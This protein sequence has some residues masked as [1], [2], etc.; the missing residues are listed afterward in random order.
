MRMRKSPVIKLY[1]L[2]CR[3]FMCI[4]KMIDKVGGINRCL[5]RWLSS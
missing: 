3:A 4:I 5:K 2:D 1:F